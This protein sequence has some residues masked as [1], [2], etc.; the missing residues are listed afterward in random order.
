MLKAKDQN[1]ILLYRVMLCSLILFANLYRQTNATFFLYS[2]FQIVF[3]I[4]LIVVSLVWIAYIKVQFFN[5]KQIMLL[6][7]IGCIACYSLLF[8]DMNMFF[9]SIFCLF[10]FQ[11]NSEE[12]IQIYNWA[13]FITLIIFCLFSFINI[14]PKWNNESLVLGFN[15][16][17]TAGY[18]ILF[19]AFSLFF[20]NNRFTF[21][22]YIAIFFSFIL[23]WH[24]V[25]DRTAAILLLLGILL[26]IV[27]ILKNKIIRIFI[28]FLP[29]FLI[30]ISIF[31]IINFGKYLWINDIDKFLSW[32]ISIWNNSWNVYNMNL[33]PQ[34]IN[35]IL[36]IARDY[37][38]WQQYTLSGFDGFF[39]LGILQDGLL[40]FIWIII[41]MTYLL[42]Y[43][44]KNFSIN[45]R[46]IYILSIVFILYN[47]TEKVSIVYFLCWLIPLAVHLE[48]ETNNEK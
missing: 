27:P 48:G 46:A 47:F 1:R 16:K 15:N 36:T 39:A 6:F 14:L 18:Y 23:E 8:K 38:M 44:V 32:R 31:L 40:L 33:L 37:S 24:F 45:N 13:I 20:V 28:I 19:V 7:V 30:F 10:F 11:L 5:K 21:V 26:F 22:N 2:F 4:L 29:V 43:Y 12:I 35:G 25:Q 3:W 34:N 41:N 42:Y 9:L 17:N